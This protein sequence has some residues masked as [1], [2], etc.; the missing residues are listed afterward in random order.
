VHN[1]KGAATDSG[2]LDPGGEMLDY[3]RRGF[4][5]RE[6]DGYASTPA[7]EPEFGQDVPRIEMVFAAGQGAG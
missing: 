5:G 4:S 6:F 3:Q 2:C 7:P 1:L